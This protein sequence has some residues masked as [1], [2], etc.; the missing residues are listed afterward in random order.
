M[1]SFH[2]EILTLHLLAGML[3]GGCAP[4]PSIPLTPSHSPPIATPTETQTSSGVTLPPSPPIYLSEL[5]MM[6]DTSGWAVAFNQADTK[7]LFLHTSDG[8][9]TWLDVTPQDNNAIGYPSYT[10]DPS[11]AQ[12]AWVIN[13]ERL[14]RTTDGG[15]TWMTVNQN[16]KQ[17]LVWPH[18]DW[19]LLHFADANRGWLDAGFAAAGAHEFY[20]ET[21]D[22]GVS[23]HPMDFESWPA[24]LYA[25]GHYK[26]EL[27]PWVVIDAIYYDSA[28]FIVVPGEQEGDI[29]M[30]LS[31][32]RGHSWK[33]VQLVLSVFPGQSFSPSDRKISRPMFFDA[34]NGALTVTRFDGDT[35]TTQ[36]SLYGTSDGGLTWTLT[37]GPT[38]MKDVHSA[39]SFLSPHDA[40]LV[41][42]SKFCI[43][44]DG[45]KTWQALDFGTF[46]PSA[47]G[48]TYFQLNFVNPA[49]GWLLFEIDTHQGVGRRARLLKTTDGGVTWTELSPLIH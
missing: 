32:N 33:T 47:Q 8:A 19:Y 17:E 49:T 10:V 21:R 3:I 27:A 18:R 31:T 40:A 11:D 13:D 35:N 38:L 23:W 34:Q 44:H 9:Q 36:L 7:V 2:A 5:Y 15:Q 1:K 20:Y 14:V 42:G 16:L 45:G 29:K 41:C 12:T 30:F 43:T 22:G 37:G 24:E 39:T 48:D 28:R 26:N 4:V 25:Q 6:D 46:L